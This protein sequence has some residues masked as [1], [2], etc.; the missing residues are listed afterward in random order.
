M[1]V[2]LQGSEKLVASLVEGSQPLYYQH[3]FGGD[4]QLLF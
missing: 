2:P 3:L 1:K 4:D